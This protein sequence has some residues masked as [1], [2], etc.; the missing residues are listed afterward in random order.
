M[1]IDKKLKKITTKSFFLKGFV[2]IL[3][4]FDNGQFCSYRGAMLLKK[5]GLQGPQM[6]S[7]LIQSI[8]IQSPPPP[9]LHRYW[10]FSLLQP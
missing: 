8:K 6:L 7:S 3:L 9:P 10:A 4:L 2:F 1:R 5:Q